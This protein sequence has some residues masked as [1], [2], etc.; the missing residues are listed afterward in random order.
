MIVGDDRGVG[1]RVDSRR[2]QGFDLAHTFGRRQRRVHP[3]E[4]S[5]QAAGPM[6][7]APFIECRAGLGLR[8]QCGR[9]VAAETGSKRVEPEIR[10]EVVGVAGCSGLLVELPGDRLAQAGALAP[11]SSEKGIQPGLPPDSN[12]SQIVDRS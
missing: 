12:S 8:V 10:A 11:T 2:R 1:V 7:D 3:I 4:R 6:A 5:F 9:V